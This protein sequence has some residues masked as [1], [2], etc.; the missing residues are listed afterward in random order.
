MG[1]GEVPAW[2]SW[3]TPSQASGC[4]GPGSPR[5]TRGKSRRNSLGPPH[6]GLHPHQRLEDGERQNEASRQAEAA[7]ILMTPVCTGW[8]A[9]A[10][11]NHLQHTPPIHS[12]PQCTHASRITH[13]ASH[14]THHRFP[15]QTAVLRASTWRN[16]LTPLLGGAFSKGAPSSLHALTHTHC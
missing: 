1:L 7:L 11:K 4:L 5:T 6:E 2:G 13:H 9:V 16:P 12:P 10:V 14:I 8:G 3:Q 15:P